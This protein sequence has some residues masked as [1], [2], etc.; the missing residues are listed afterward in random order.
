M[1][2]LWIPCNLAAF[3]LTLRASQQREPILGRRN[4]QTY[5]VHLQPQGYRPRV[6]P[7]RVV[8]LTSISLQPHEFHIWRYNPPP[9]VTR[10]PVS[11]RF[12]VD[13]PVCTGLPRA[14]LMAWP[15]ILV[16]HVC[17]RLHLL[18][19]IERLFRRSIWTLSL[20]LQGSGRA[21]YYLKP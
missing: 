16:V 5:L 18:S 8:V 2:D 20:G 19:C 7:C 14:P 13:S 4:R 10:L 11:L 9:T 21:G 1:V 3:R 15:W 12:R 6:R 17:T